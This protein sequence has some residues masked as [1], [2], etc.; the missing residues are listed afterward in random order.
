[1]S[2]DRTRPVQGLYRMY[3]KSLDIAWKIPAFPWNISATAVSRDRTRPVL[4]LLRT[5]GKALGIA[6]KIPAFP[7]NFSAAE[8]SKVIA[9]L[10]SASGKSCSQVSGSDC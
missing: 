10:P 6:W 2:K 4:G 7:W 5:Y 8:V 1:M 3:G 9:P